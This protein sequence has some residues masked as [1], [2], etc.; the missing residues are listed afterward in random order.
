[1]ER[2]NTKINQRRHRPLD[3]GL[4]TLFRQLHCSQT[5]SHSFDCDLQAG[6]WAQGHGSIPSRLNGS[7]ATWLDLDGWELLRLLCN[8]I[9]DLVQRK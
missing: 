1:M 9:A 7:L 5:L 2:T 3:V 6:G 8:E 4:S